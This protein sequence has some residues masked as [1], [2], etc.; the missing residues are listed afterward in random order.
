MRPLPRFC[1]SGGGAERSGGGDGGVAARRIEKRIE[2]MGRIIAAP[3]VTIAARRW[4]TPNDPL[5]PADGSAA[6]RRL[7]A[8]PAV[9]RGHA[10]GAL[11]PARRGRR[12]P[13]PRD[14]WPSA[15]LDLVGAPAGRAVAAARQRLLGLR[16]G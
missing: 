5:L 16:P 10:L 1:A 9:A 14:P 15:F 12:I 7:R 6:C 4:R 8:L 13:R 2:I 11:A 3:R